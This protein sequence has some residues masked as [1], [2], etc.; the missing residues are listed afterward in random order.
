MDDLLKLRQEID[1]ID[2]ELVELF[3]KRMEVV[4][5]VSS[6]KKENKIEVINE[7]RETEVINKG[8]KLLKDKK[9]EDYLVKFF[10]NLMKISKEMQ[11]E[12]LSARSNGLEEDEQLTQ[13]SATQN[14]ELL[15]QSSEVI[16]ER[17]LTQCSTYRENEL[18]A[19]C[20]DSSF[21]IKRLIIDKDMSK[22]II[23]GFQG[24]AGSY[25]QQALFEYFGSEINTKSVKEFEDIFIE[26]KNNKIDYGVLPIENSS[27]G[28]ISEVYDLLNKYDFYISGEICIKINHHLLGIKG[29]QIDDIKEVYSHTQ[30]FGQCSDFLKMYPD[31]MLIPYQ[32]T[33]KSAQFIKEKNCRS[34]AAIGSKRASEIYDLEILQS[35]IN[36]NATNTT[37]FAVIS[38][39]RTVDENCNKISVV[40]ST[41]HKAGCLFNVLRYFAQNNINLL[42]LESR[43]IVDKPWEY[44]FY[45]DF[46]GNLND[47]TVKLAVKSIEENSHYFKLLG[48]YKRYQENG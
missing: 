7:N 38:K 20:E 2:K 23:V 35:N 15:T 17:V 4:L 13:S 11:Y 46:E 3:E 45:I 9:L 41:A 28:A 1:S 12:I 19:K 44:F 40:L 36:S 22:Q 43:P 27:T 8:K 14:Y 18:H 29:A 5:K 24:V 10:F 42:K 47:Q 30:G 39:N 34:M 25:S 37:R 26:L 33:A 32:N 48:N 6:Y 31:W 16:K 21:D